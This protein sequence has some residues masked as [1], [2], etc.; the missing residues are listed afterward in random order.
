MGSARGHD[1]AQSRRRLDLALSSANP[2]Q[3]GVL[4]ARAVMAA[5]NQ[6]WRAAAAFTAAASDLARRQHAASPDPGG[7]PSLAMVDAITYG[8]LL[9][10]ARARVGDFAGARAALQGTPGDC[11]GCVRE[12]GRIAAMQGQ[13]PEAE[14][15]F[16][17]AIRQGP[18]L[19][20]AHLD[21]G[22]MLL[23]KGEPAAAIL[24]LRIAHD[25]GPR[26]ADPL[27]RW[28]EALMAQRRFEDAAAKFGNAE[29]LAPAWG[30]ARL[31]QGEALML[32]GRY[33]Q[34]REEFGSTARL[35]LSAP[36]RAALNLLLARTA[37][38]PL[39]G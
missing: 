32:A 23:R 37:S 13:W 20:F 3:V 24:S 6:D 34:A 27:E 10:E 14:R 2:D 16:A 33:A 35:D 31:L 9:A 30:H 17:E 4:H 1:M 28:G 19:P 22:E 39:H 38:G 36:D 12:R 21:R 29:A 7:L 8:P 5:E 18:S 15:W 26:F 25:K 11:Y